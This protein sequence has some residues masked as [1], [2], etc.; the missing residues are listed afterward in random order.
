[1]R[2]EKKD[3][4]QLN[5]PH[6]ILIVW[7]IVSL[8]IQVDPSMCEFY[9]NQF[10]HN[11]MQCNWNL[12][13]PFQLYVLCQ[14]IQ[15][16]HFGMRPARRQHCN[17]KV[18]AFGRRCTTATRKK[19]KQRFIIQ[20]IKTENGNG[21][22]KCAGITYKYLSIARKLNDTWI[23]SFFLP[24]IQRSNSEKEKLSVSLC[25]FDCVQWLWTE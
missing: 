22:K 6:F 12:Q 19:R 11:R 24:V 25:L 16:H 8:P 7:R 3:P 1:M 18:L 9:R 23:V 14:S 15:A 2:I 4:I 21:I 13:S 17:Q 20:K 10:D 5:E